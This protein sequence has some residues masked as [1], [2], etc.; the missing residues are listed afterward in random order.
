MKRTNTDIFGSAD[1]VPDKNV[2]LGFLAGARIYVADPKVATCFVSFEITF[3]S[4]L[5]ISYFGFRGESQIMCSKPA[6]GNTSAAISGYMSAEYY[7]DKKMFDAVFSVKIDFGD[8]MRGS[9]YL[10]I[11]SQP[12]KF[13]LYIGTPSNPCFIKILGLKVSSYFMVGFIPEGTY[14]LNADCAQKWGD[15]PYLGMGES[16]N[17]IALGMKISFEAS[18]NGKISSCLKAYAYLTL[19]GGSD[20][21]LLKGDFCGCPWRAWGDSYFHFGGGAGVKYRW[22]RACSWH[23]VGINASGKARLS[24]EVPSPAYFSGDLFVTVPI[25]CGWEP[26][27]KVQASFGERC[28]K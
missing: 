11:H 24:A 21:V 6:P 4:N 20:L 8:L 9:A 18:K 7:V 17:G 26:T 10:Q 13:Y 3:N 22:C 12:N 27:F 19:N 15:S 1:Y 5:G 28:K 14:K 2:S 25:C 23:D 16:G